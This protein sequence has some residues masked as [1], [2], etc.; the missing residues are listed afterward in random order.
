MSKLKEPVSEF[1]VVG[2]LLDFVIKDGY[3]IKY[4]RINVSNIEYWIKLSKPLRKSLDPAIIPGAWIEVSGTSKLK[5]K[6]GKLKLKAYEVSLAA[7]PH[8]Q[9]TTVLETKT[10]SRKASILVCQKSSCRKRGGQA[11]CNAIA[12]SLK[13]HGLEDQVK[14]K[15][16]GCLKQCKHG[17]NLVMMPDK[18]RYSQVAPQQIP[19]LIERHFV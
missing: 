8:Q 3:K 19:T 10:P 1:S 15:E 9:P 7:H 2:Q 11:V 17:P 12:S 4:L 5:R 13:D 14:I 6:T 18:A 16:T